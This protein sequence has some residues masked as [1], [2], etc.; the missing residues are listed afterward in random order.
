MVVP[1]AGAVR[2]AGE[3][4]A[5]RPPT[6]VLRRGLGYVP[7]GRCNFPAMSV[8]ENLEMGAY[9]RSD[10]GVRDDIDALLARFPVLADKRRAAAGT[11]S[12][13]QQQILE[14]AIALLLHPKLM[15][16]DE[17]SLGLDPRMVDAVFGAI[18][19]SNREGAT[20]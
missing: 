2:F 20:F 19:T 11:L 14:M 6:E 1:R 16:I 8:E 7:Q 13:G 12:G 10:D 3:E 5:G 18:Q 15:L 9:L 17:P 4:I